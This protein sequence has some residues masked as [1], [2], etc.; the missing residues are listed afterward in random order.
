[1]NNVNKTLYIPLFGKALV[2]KKGIILEDKRAEKI[3]ESLGFPLG[4]KSRSKYLAYYMAMRARVFDD[5][6]REKTAERPNT[7]VL[8]LGAGLDSRALRVGADVIWYDVDFPEVIAEREKHFCQTDTYRM[9]SSDIRDTAFLDRLP[10]APHATLVLEGVSMYLKNEELCHTLRALTEHFESVSLLVDC[11]TPFAAKMS[12]VK[13]P[14]KE[15]GVSEVFGV[16]SPE[17]FTENTGLSFVREREITPNYL[18]DELSGM[19]R[20]LFRSLYAGGFSKK[21][22]KL[23]E[24]ENKM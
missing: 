9:I 17:I 11:Y 2:S 16:K 5:F 13:N 21:L 20:A 4:R 1:M 23:Y 6:V 12:K 15:V 3:W 14:V 24:Y 10:K 19:E 7:V 18:V 22:Y 8:H